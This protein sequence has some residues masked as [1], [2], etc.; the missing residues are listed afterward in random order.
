MN[1]TR[2]KK[3]LECVE[4]MERVLKFALT[5]VDETGDLAKHIRDTQ[6]VIVCN[7]A[8]DVAELIQ[9]KGTIQ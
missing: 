3:A 7:C 4:H 2:I 9:D 8:L 5:A 6:A 1:E